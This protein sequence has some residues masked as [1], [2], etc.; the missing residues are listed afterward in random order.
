[1]AILQ[2]Q[3]AVF[4]AV[5]MIIVAGATAAEAQK[6]RDERI[7]AKFTQSDL[8]RILKSE[9]YGSVERL[10]DDA[11]TF[12]IDGKIYGL[13]IFKDNDLQLH[14]GTAGIEVPLSKMNGWNKDFRHSRAY[15]DKEGDPILEA[16]L[17]ADEG[18]SGAMVKNFISVFIISVARFRKDILGER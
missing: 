10:N 8:V 15:I 17:L 5:V 13:F 18:L 7:Q 3:F 1:M 16:D 9:G 14:Y 12:K 6:S 2:K 4:L 11:V